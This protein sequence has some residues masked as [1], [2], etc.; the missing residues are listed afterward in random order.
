MRQSIRHRIFSD[1]VA[2]LL[3]QKRARRAPGRSEHGTARFDSAQNYFDF[4]DTI[5]GCCGL[6]FSHSSRSV[7][8]TYAPEFMAVGEVN[9][10][11]RT[12]VT[13]NFQ[14]NVHQLAILYRDS[15]GGLNAAPH[16]D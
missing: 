9:Y 2:E 7:Q 6:K 11:T 3:S 10:G 14:A 16:E 8:S 1:C 12:P 4:R 5:F 15:T 13:D